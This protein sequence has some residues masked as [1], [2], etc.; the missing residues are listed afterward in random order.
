[1]EC[2]LRGNCFLLVFVR[3]GDCT[4][5][6]VPV[7]PYLSDLLQNTNRW[8]NV[9][10]PIA[11]MQAHKQVSLRR[12]WKG[13]LLERSSRGL[14]RIRGFSGVATRIFINVVG[15]SSKSGVVCA[16]GRAIGNREGP[17]PAWQAEYP[18]RELPY[19]ARL[20]AV[21]RCARVRSS[22]DGI[23]AARAAFQGG[24]RGMS[25][26]SGIRQG[27]QPV[28]GLPRGYPSA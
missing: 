22:Q 19:D 25:H 6:S 3:A 9:R 17:Q 11:E 26:R 24:L 1:M 28:P 7:G 23:C 21:T 18:L 4:S 2:E 16:R 5:D 8:W 12:W 20:E 27:W 13:G 15:H 14:F 10:I